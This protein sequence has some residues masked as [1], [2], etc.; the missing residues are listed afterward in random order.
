MKQPQEYSRRR[1]GT[2]FGVGLQIVLATILLGAV[3]YAGFHYYLRGDWSPNQRYRL[4]DQTRSLIRN[5]PAPVNVYVF[6]SPTTAAPGFEV[7]GDVI[8]LLKEYQSA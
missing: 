1:A 7:Y 6:F 8:N 5:L 3:N 2:R 4:S